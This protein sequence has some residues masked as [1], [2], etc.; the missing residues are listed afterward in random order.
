MTRTRMLCLGFVLGACAGMGFAADAQDIDRL[1]QQLGSGKFAERDAAQKALDAIGPDALA[2][3]RKAAASDD[4]EISRRAKE[5][6]PLLELRAET[7]DATKPK[8]VSLV[9][10]DQSATDAIQELKRVTGLPIALGGDT[11]ALANK[12]VTLE[13]KDVSAWEALDRFCAAAGLAQDV[14]EETPPKQPPIP[15]GQF[16]GGGINVMDMEGLPQKKFNIRLQ[17]GKPAGYPTAYV[18]ALRVRALPPASGDKAP[19]KG[20]GAV[21]L[22]VLAEPGFSWRGAPKLRVDK[23]VDDK[24]QAVTQVAIEDAPAQATEEIIIQGR[25]QAIIRRAMIVNGNRVQ[26]EELYPS[27]GRSDWAQNLNVKLKLPDDP[28]VSLKQ[29]KGMLQGRVSVPAQPLVTVHDPLAVAKSENKVVKGKGIDL[30]LMSATKQDDGTVKTSFEMTGEGAALGAFAA[31]GVQI[32]QNVGGQINF[33]A[34]PLADAQHVRLLDGDGKPYRITAFNSSSRVNN[35]VASNEYRC[36]FSPPTAT[37]E[38]KKLEYIGSRQ[39]TVEVPFE[40][41]DVALERGK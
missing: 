14:V 11:A 28:G 35:G 31:G 7:A 29:F 1:I 5:L 33:N 17:D 27:G 22:E 36:T 41:K 26:M 21:K 18:G 25:G 40:L 15:R 23:A 32:I 9:C 34:E 24:N 8:R 2:A 19:A 12:K 30:K 39:A 20:E 13:L 16:R 3:L 38:P 4:A 10:K 37:S 6:I